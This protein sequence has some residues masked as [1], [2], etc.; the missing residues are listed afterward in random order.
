[1]FNA[2]FNKT[3]L[4]T[5]AAAIVATGLSL[6]PAMAGGGGGGNDRAGLKKS[7]ADW[8]SSTYK[9]GKTVT[10][11]AKKG[12]KTRTVVTT[13]DG[14]LVDVRKVRNSRTPFISMTDESGN[15]R[16]VFGKRKKSKKIW[17]SST[18]RN[19]ETITSTG[20]NGVPTRDVV[21]TRNGNVVETKQ[22]DSSKA[23]ITM[24]N[25]NGVDTTIRGR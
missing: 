13:Q 17:A 24:H 19:G 25:P 3:I 15:I 14:N 4:S 22:I 7:K 9:S 10:S 16:I 23:F 18:H 20:Q 11:Y 12:S 5:L 1:M 21:T 6:N 8:A 2:T